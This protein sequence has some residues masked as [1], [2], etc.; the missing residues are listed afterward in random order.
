MDTIFLQ[1][2]ILLS[3]IF[4]Y[5]YLQI[6]NYNSTTRYG[7]TSYPI[8]GTV[9]EFVLNCHRFLDW[10]A[11]VLIRTPSHTGILDRPGKI[12]VFLTANPANVEH[13]VKT[14]FDNYP[15][16]TRFIS[17]LEELLGNGIFNAEGE[18]W[19]LQRKISSYEFNTRSLRNFVMEAANVELQ[20][21]LIPILERASDINRVFDLQDVFER[22]TF[23][24]ICKVAFNFDP[25]CLS[26]DG[27]NNSEFMS[28]FE[29]ATTLITQR[30]IRLCPGDQKIRKFFKLK[31]E[32]KLE[33]AI[34]TVH[35]FADDIIKK[36][37]DERDGKTDEDLLSRFMGHSDY[38]PKFLR[39]IVVSFI[40]AGRDTTSSAL[41]WFFWLL[42]SHPEVER[43]ILDELR[44]IRRKTGKSSSE[45]YCFDDL[46]HM[47]YLHGALSE[48]LRLYP[49]VPLETKD[50]LKDDV[51][52]DGTFIGKGWFVT[53]NAYAMARIESVWGKDCCEFR[54]E[55]W[56]EEDECG[57]VVY[58]PE[59]PFKFPAFHGGPRICVGKEMAYTQMKLV[60]ATIIEKF[61]VEVLAENKNPPQHVLALTIRMKDGLKVRVWKR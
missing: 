49:P 61:R 24:S 14:N 16:G 7:F 20:D 36:R 34:A 56:L 11:E 59:S 60:A 39:D 53:Y 50:S 54:P 52:P 3:P 10:T 1:A 41:S 22:Y 47:H 17:L 37:M 18:S 30:F 23:D 8:V 21:R 58:R 26:G 9:P 31:S 43:K 42:S 51:M 45:S 46:R 38:S 15:K 57:N 35:K 2:L 33:K 28:A 5:I 12:K 40:L 48:G 29:E 4:L 32:M 55:R 19:R 27:T 13:M 6:K 25:C 44:S